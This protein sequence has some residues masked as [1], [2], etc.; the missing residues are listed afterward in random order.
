MG[1]LTLPLELL[2][3]IFALLEGHEIVRCITVCSYFKQAIE[4]SITLQYFIKL[5]MFG[6][7]NGPGNVDAARLSQLER[8]IDAWNK[9]DWVESR[10]DLPAWR[11]LTKTLR[12]GVYATSNATEM[13]CIQLPSL[14]RG[15]PLRTWKLTFE[16]RVHQTEIDPSNNLLVVL[17]L[18]R[19]SPPD[20]F[21][22]HLR[23]L[24]DN[25]P[26]PSAASPIL[27]PEIPPFS[28]HGPC[29]IRVMGFLIG[30]AD[31]GA[32]EI[33]NWTTGQKITM[34][35]ADTPRVTF[36]PFEFLSTT[37]FLLPCDGRLEV[38]QVPMESPGAPPLH[39]ASFCM[40]DLIPGHAWICWISHMP[41]AS[42]NMDNGD[43][44]ASPSSLPPPPFRMTKDSRCIEMSWVVYEVHYAGRESLNTPFQ[45]PLSSLH[46]SAIYPNPLEIP[47]D[48]W[49]KGVYFVKEARGEVSSKMSGGRHIHLTHSSDS[50][51]TVS[52]LDLNRY[53]AGAL[54]TNADSSIDDEQSRD[55]IKSDVF[56]LGEM[57]VGHRFPVHV[58]SR[59][60]SLG[61]YRP[62]PLICDDECIIIHAFPPPEASPVFAE[63]YKFDKLII[64]SF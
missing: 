22:L 44:L 11:S 57:R 21:A 29:R 32:L 43:R 19:E 37:S 3:H 17:A 6:Y 15:V 50:H 1:L 40:P 58:A 8:H 25:I 30:L 64:L 38:Y 39:T 59:S 63:E 41:R 51:Y 28:Y 52:L 27:F 55:P 56:S 4:D 24:S 33:W 36:G 13:T 31:M 14:S 42:H 5:D 9:L 16:P 54:G 48:A 62:S 45:V 10:I 2:I 23:T 34:V 46:H 7:T 18:M 60:L 35:R 20:S 26:H 12:G 53:R 47:W 61:G 49:S